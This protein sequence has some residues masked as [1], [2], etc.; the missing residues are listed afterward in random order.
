M[1]E[2]KNTEQTPSVEEVP[3]N[4]P[5]ENQGDTSQ[6]INLPKDTIQE[7]I[8]PVRPSVSK[9][10]LKKRLAILAITL[11]LIAAG[12]VAAWKFIPE[13]NKKDSD[14]TKTSQSEAN[15]QESTDQ[16]ADIG[17]TTLSETYTSD[18]LRITLKHPKSWQVSDDNNA[19]LVKSPNFKLK[20]KNGTETDSYFKIYIRRGATQNDGTYLGKGYAIAQSEKLTYND[21][22]TGQ[23]K[24]TLLTNF[25]IDTPDNFAYFVVQGNF[26]LK[27]GDTLGPKFA[28]EVDSFLIAG[29]FAGAEQKDGLSTKIVAEDSFAENPAYL[30]AVEIVKTLQLK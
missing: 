11:I 21:P 14:P 3:I 30:T 24:D 1:P 18:F 19:V 4:T 22:A 20:E 26:N 6:Y 28:S 2:D 10:H 15:Q 23:R 12:A 29:G 17:D 13:I 8:P 25:G 7:Q 9:S 5:E 16:Q 27:K